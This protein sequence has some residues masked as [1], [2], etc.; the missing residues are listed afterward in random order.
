M[1]IAYPIGGRNR[2]QMILQIP[3]RKRRSSMT[4]VTLTASEF[5]DHVGEASIAR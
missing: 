1:G 5:Q 3:A 4:N 2:D